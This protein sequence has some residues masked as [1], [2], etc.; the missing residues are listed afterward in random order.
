MKITRPFSNEVFIINDFITPEEVEKIVSFASSL[1][2]ESWEIMNEDSHTPPEARS[3]AYNIDDLELFNF[4][5]SL[6]KKA[7]ILLTE[8][9]DLEEELFLTGF[10]TIMR[11]FGSGML[12]HWDG[13][14]GQSQITKYG[15]VLYLNTCGKDFDGGELFY[16]EFGE[17]YVPLAGDLVIHPGSKQYSHAV[18]DVSRGTRYVLTSFA[19]T[20]AHH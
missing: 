11:T 6:N 19:K 13:G 15:L 7:M 16:P 2:Q 10:Y 5:E 1:S 9:Y 14:D 3:K 8:L 18:L 12:A 17:T 20:V 4:C